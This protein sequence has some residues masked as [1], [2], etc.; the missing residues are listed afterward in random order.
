MESK[1]NRATIRKLNSLQQTLLC[2]SDSPHWTSSWTLPFNY[3]KMQQHDNTMIIY[4]LDNLQEENN[5][6]KKGF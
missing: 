3:Q 1:T 2:Y 5:C 6:K 4:V